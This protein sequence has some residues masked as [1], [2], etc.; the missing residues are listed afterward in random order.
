MKI[1]S[2]IGPASQ[3][4]KFVRFCIE[5]GQPHFRINAS[6]LSVRQLE[7]ILV[8]LERLSSPQQAEV[9]LDIQGGKKRIGNLDAPLSLKKNERVLLVP[10]KN[11]IPQKQGEKPTVPVPDWENLHRLS[12]GTILYLQDNQIQ[13]RILENRGEEIIAEVVNASQQLR[14]RAGI[15]SKGQPALSGRLPSLQLEQLQ[16]AAQ[17]RVKNI[18]L[19]F[20]SGPNDILALREI[21][22]EN[23]YTPDLI[24][25]IER[26]E[27]LTHLT[28]IAEAADE[29][30]FCRGDLGTIIPLKNLGKA[31]DDCIEICR[32]QRVPVVVAGQVFHH[33]TEH[34]QPTRS[35][36][37]HFYHLQQTGVAGIVLSDETAIGT[38]PAN[39]VSQI[40]QLL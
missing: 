33:L 11:N 3:N 17:F 34:E 32:K 2:T 10:E 40:L 23:N 39:A 36:V 28:R 35:E 4:L 29:V 26:P 8:Q 7:E 5:H 16:V 30:W 13:L 12:T 15:W 21:L 14:S 19:S 9:T 27:A 22:R 31:Q 25:K 6:H 38:N 20:V 1:I 24:A 18:A 37:V